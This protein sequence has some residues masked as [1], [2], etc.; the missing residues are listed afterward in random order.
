MVLILGVPQLGLKEV[1]VQRYTRS[2]KILIL[3]EERQVRTS[4]FLAAETWILSQVCLFFNKMAA[5]CLTVVTKYVIN[6]T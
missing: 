2:L 5:T 6:Q 1:T 4:L 3:Q